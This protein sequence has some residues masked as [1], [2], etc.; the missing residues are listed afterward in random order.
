MKKFKK[1]EIVNEHSFPIILKKI[2]HQMNLSR[3]QLGIKVGKTEQQIQR[4]ETVKGA[5]VY[6]FPPLNVLKNI[7]V[8]LQVDANMLLGLVWNQS[9]K[10]FNHS[11]VYEWN[12]KGDSIHWICPIC[13]KENIT[14]NDFRKKPS[15][16]KTQS[17]QCEYDDCGVYFE[18]LNLEKIK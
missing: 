15:L 12:L 8:A 13:R 10:P 14:Y 9:D 18:K 1:L 5:G 7:C 4:Y 16:I 6:Q 11:I 3:K 2:R 17:L